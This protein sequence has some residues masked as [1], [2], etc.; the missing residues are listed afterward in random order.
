MSKTILLS[1]TSCADCYFLNETGNHQHYVF[2]QYTCKLKPK[3][4]KERQ[5]GG[6]SSIQE[7]WMVDKAVN[8]RTFDPRCPLPEMMKHQ[9]PTARKAEVR[10]NVAFEA[11]CPE[12]G[13][14]MIGVM[15]PRFNFELSCSNTDCVEFIPHSKRVG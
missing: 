2:G 12:C 13:S 9:I 10:L 6:N 4:E 1:I 15:V 5:N 11:K 7:A 8:E 3:T 14:L